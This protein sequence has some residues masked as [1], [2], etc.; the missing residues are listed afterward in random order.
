MTLPPL[1]RGAAATLRTR[2]PCYLVLFVTRRCNAACPFCFYPIN[3]PDDALSVDEIE[4]VVTRHPYFLQVTLS[5]G[6]PYLRSDLAELVE[7]LARAGR[8]RFLTVSSNGSLPERIAGVV[9]RVLAS[10]PDLRYRASLSVDDLPEQHEEARRIPGLFE[11]I[12][13]S[14]AALVRLA[15][16][17]PGRLELNVQTVLSGLNK[18]RIAE[19]HAFLAREL[20]RC[21]RSLVLARG[22][23][24]DPA[25]LDVTAD[26][27]EH[28]ARLWA[29]SRP[30]RD[31]LREP[32]YAVLDATLDY[33]QEVVTRVL[34]ADP[35]V[36]PCAAGR[37]LVVIDTNGDVLPCEMRHVVRRVTGSDVLGNLRDHDHD[38]GRLLGAA[39]AR[40][41]VDRIRSRGCRCTFECA[42][43]ASVAFSPPRL[44]TAVVRRTLRSALR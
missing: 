41:A 39:D 22:E 18:A 11:R 44:V 10:C 4:R 37:R 5:G 19:V 21:R 7:V 14:Y 24:P 8:V 15:D 17:H 2:V 43:N 30:A 23:V 36:P 40:V 33:Q 27:Y 28:A 38:L 31:A 9:E 16:R 13:A 26:E 34:R 35:A 1:L 12:R 3:T 20:P 25:S 6:E 29:A 32:H 42:I